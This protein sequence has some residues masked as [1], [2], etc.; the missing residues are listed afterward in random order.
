MKRAP[1]GDEAA[2][3]DARQAVGTPAAESPAHV[4][5][6][7]DGNGRWAQARGLPRYRGHHSGV[8]AVRRT[9]RAAIELDIRYLTIY[10]FSSEN[11]RRPAAEIAE[12]MGLLKL[13]IRRDLAD[14]A[15]NNVRVRIIGDRAGLPDDVVALLDE[16][17]ARTVGCT[18]LT[19]IVAFNYGGRQELAR[20]ARALARQAQ[21]G[22][23][24]P[25][26]ITEDMLGAH[27]DT[28]GIP[29]PDLLIRTSGEQRLSNF[30]LWQAAYAELVF[31]PIYWPDFDR[32]ALEAAIAEFRRRERRFGSVGADA[33]I[34]ED[35]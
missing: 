28:V 17:Q 12:L 24:A 31:M 5:I 23:I 26:D 4:A 9:V 6:I 33:V 8:E 14:L 29:D 25:D 18:G 22:E 3:D 27:L 10:S 1:V 32:A 21:Q 19:L 16:A 34:D 20:A 13:F 35:V 7:M 11:W 15:R 2:T 30:L